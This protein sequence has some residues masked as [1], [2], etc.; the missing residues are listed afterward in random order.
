MRIVKPGRIHVAIRQ[1][2]GRVVFDIYLIRRQ[3]CVGPPTRLLHHCGLEIMV[4]AFLFHLSFLHLLQLLLHPAVD[5][6]HQLELLLALWKSIHIMN[7]L[8]ISSC[9]SLSHFE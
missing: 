8:I 7:S 9:E 2:H 5:D 4:C 6:L 3:G 1:L